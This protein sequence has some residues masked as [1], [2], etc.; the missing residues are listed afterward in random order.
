MAG[1]RDI[2]LYQGH[3]TPK[4]IIL[5]ALPV[6]STT[7]TTIWLVQGHATPKDIILRNVVVA[8]TPSGGFPT[9]FSGLRVFYGGTVKDLCLVAEADANTGMG[10]V[11]KVRKGGTT[12]AVY[13]VETGDTNASSVRIRT[14]T[15]VKSIRLKT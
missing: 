6:A 12:Y 8:P 10:G 3:A 1:Q 15:G 13:L 4:D 5:R 14:S 9:Q 11:P 7:S 2:T